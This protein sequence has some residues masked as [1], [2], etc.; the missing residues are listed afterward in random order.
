MDFA[1]QRAAYVK[2][3]EASL[4]RA[5]AEW[6]APA[7]APEIRVEDASAYALL[8]GGKRLRAMLALAAGETMGLPAA[9]AERIAVAVETLHAYSLVHDDLP[10]MDDADTRRGQP[11]VHRKFDE[12]TAI[13][14]GDQLLTY[15][16]G[17]LAD[18]PAALRALSDAG[19]QMVRGQMLD[20]LSE[21]D[22]VELDLAALERLQAQKTGAII[23][24]ACEAP[25]L[26]ANDPDAASALRRF[27]T[28]L[29]L[30]FQ[31]TDD[32]LDAVSDAETLGK[33]VGAD[34]EAGK[35][36]FV[37]LLGLEAARTRS[38]QEISAAKAA[39]EPLQGHIRQDGAALAFLSSLADFVLSRRN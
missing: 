37:T 28:H 18:L 26:V 35:A 20:L 1:T 5:F 16:L 33:P 24:F 8:G 19:A 10:A 17:H 14:A 9:G 22:G 15:A 12:V 11:S 21:R 29:G 13:L 25:A 31:I 34:A 4:T 6:S 27:G 38:E 2:R 36:T 7:F 23:R 32:I 30:A 3:I 39:L